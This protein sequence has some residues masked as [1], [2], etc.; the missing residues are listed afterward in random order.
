MSYVT[1]GLFQKNNWVCITK[2]ILSDSLD[3]VHV[4]TLHVQRI[5]FEHLYL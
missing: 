5:A 3:H 4:Y 1:L 2:S